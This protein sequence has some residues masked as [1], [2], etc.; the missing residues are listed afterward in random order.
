VGRRVIEWKTIL[1]ETIE[2][3]RNRNFA[4]GTFDCCLF[5]A[6]CVD[7]MTGSNFVEELKSHYSNKKE[8]LEWIKEAGGLD[9]IVSSYLGD[10]VDPA[11]IG[12]GDVVMING[13]PALGIFDGR[14]VLAT[15]KD[16]L[17][18]LPHSLIVK[19]WKI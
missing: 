10:A 9:A 17:V 2:N 5:P 13:N 16:D 1:K 18:L 12:K 8:A 19:G 3:N 14:H 7:A 6:I 4:W 15:G 11:F